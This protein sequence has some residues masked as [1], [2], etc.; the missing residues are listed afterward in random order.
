L[1]TQEVSKVREVLLEYSLNDKN[2]KLAVL[3]K[4]ADEIFVPAATMKLALLGKVWG[5][6]TL[7]E[8]CRVRIIADP[9]SHAS[10]PLWKSQLLIAGIT[11]ACARSVKHLT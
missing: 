9:L 7:Y 3:K 2:D 5:Y 4:A 1:Q 10:S 11:S 8:S 6:D